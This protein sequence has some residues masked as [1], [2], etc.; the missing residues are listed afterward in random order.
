MSEALSE[1]TR[2]RLSLIN[3]SSKSQSVVMIVYYFHR[4]RNTYG[5]GSNGITWVCFERREIKTNNPYLDMFNSHET[6]SFYIVSHLMCCCCWTSG[7]NKY[8]IANSN[9]VFK[10]IIII[11]T[12][13]TIDY[14]R[15]ISDTCSFI[16]LCA[17]KKLML[18]IPDEFHV[19]M[20]TKWSYFD[21]SSD[22]CILG[23]TCDR[24]V[25][26]FSARLKSA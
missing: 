4:M 22:P 3:S 9:S 7:V 26:L 13:T 14:T 15:Y 21:L 11:A 6:S 19:H 1:D 16:W 5:K 25:L 23:L 8:C 18:S 24:G 17:V 12:T 10:G 2:V 20:E